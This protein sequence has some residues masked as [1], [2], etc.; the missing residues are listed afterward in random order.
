MPNCTIFNASGDKLA[1]FSTE[2]FGS[3][4]T[5]GRSSDCTICL[6]GLANTSI[7][8]VHLILIGTPLGWK[9][10]NN[11][12]A[13]MYKDCIKKDEVELNDGDIIR[14]AGLFFAYGN[15]AGP[16]PF[17]IAWD[18]QT[19]DGLFFNVLWPGLN[20]IGASHDNYVMVR[21]VDVSRQHAF[22]RISA[23]NQ[24]TLRAA[25]LNNNTYVNGE[26]IGDKEVAL[27]P[28]DVIQMADTV[29]RFV[30]AVRVSFNNAPIQMDVNRQVSIANSDS[31]NSKTFM[32]VMIGLFTALITT[33]LLL[34]ITM[35]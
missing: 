24:A 14:F 6:K 13:G 32:Y 1:V 21:T 8:R 30:S 5:I 19:E 18:E 10:R 2:R 27:K 33:L 4:I 20:S 15:T 23:N 26:E 22:I 17:N 12:K 34:L 16:A 9:L 31:V 25:T 7:S 3:Q 11:S 29:V 28:D 35:L